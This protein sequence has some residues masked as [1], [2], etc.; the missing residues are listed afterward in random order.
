M[1]RLLLA[2]LVAGMSGPAALGAQASTVVLVRHAEKVDTSRAAGLTASGGLRA[3]ALRAVLAAFPLQAIFVSEYPRTSA[4]AAPTAG[5]S[6][7]TPTVVPI[8]GDKLAQAAGIASMVR[9]MPPG[10]AALVIGHSNTL[11]LIIAALGGPDVPEL[12][13]GEHATLFV[14]DLPYNLPPRLLRASYGAP[15]PP[16]A[17]TCSQTPP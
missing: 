7:L 3:E 11:G 9:D 4:T 16:G 2:V 13:D 12:C 8:Q 1:R 17:E 6:H 5:A 14:L 15:D 10:S